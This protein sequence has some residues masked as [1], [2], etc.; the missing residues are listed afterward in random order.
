M[1]VI[2]FPPPR[3]GGARPP[4]AGEPPGLPPRGKAALPIAA[5][6]AAPGQPDD[7][8]WVEDDR[9]ILSLG[10][11]GSG[12]TT[13]LA[14]ALA[15]T[16]H[17]AIVH[18]PKG[19]LARMTAA[20]RLA[21]GQRVVLIDP[22]GIVAAVPGERGGINPMDLIG[23]AGRDPTQLSTALD[24]ALTLADMAAPLESRTDPYWDHM[25]RQV[26]QGLLLWGAARLPAADRTIA[27]LRRL[28]AR[29]PWRARLLAA[30]AAE[31]TLFDGRLPEVAEQLTSLPDKTYECVVSTTLQK[32][33][34]AESPGFA[35]VMAHS[36]PGLSD[37][38]AGDQPTTV[39]LCI[40]AYRL[41]SHRAPVAMMLTTVIRALM[42]RTGPVRQRTLLAIDEAALL[43]GNGDIL[44]AAT[45][46]RGYGVQTWLF[47]QS[48]HQAVAS[49]GEQEARTLLDNAGSITIGGLGC[50]GLFTREAA[51]LT[52]FPDPDLL[53]GQPFGRLLVSQPGRR[54]RL[55]QQ[56]S[57]LD[58][59]LTGLLGRPP[60]LPPR[61]ER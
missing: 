43:G 41:R 12:K 53:H 54:A 11:S 22:D 28:F 27:T 46:M 1:T 48:W 13:M 44:T 37:L 45:L 31:D 50:S 47:Y 3:H 15:A 60:A 57:H 6:L 51:A 55:A 2:R 7:I 52:G 24:D 39:Y 42:R 33:Q 61:D 49:F 59:R 36:T 21:M 10:P 19:E 9:P 18:D 17:S 20:R 26:I 5:E 14:C 16:S 4:G 56:L 30:L 38:V 32:L 58:R 29:P 40:P 34:W 25:A 35:R 8:V 23:P